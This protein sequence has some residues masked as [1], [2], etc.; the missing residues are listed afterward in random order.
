MP[1]G[2]DVDFG[3]LPP[4]QIRSLIREK[5]PDAV[6]G[7]A[8]GA[9]PANAATSAAPPAEERGSLMD[10]VMQGVTFGFA[11]EIA[12]GFGGVMDWMGFGPKGSEGTFSE[13]YDR[14]VNKAR[15]NLDAYR[16]RNPT[17]ALVGEIGGAV[18]TLPVAGAMNI[19]RAPAAISKAAPLAA[20]AANSVG[21]GAAA[22]ANSAATGAAY[23]AAYG[24]GAA[25]GDIGERASGALEGGTMGGILGAAAPA[26]IGVG[27]KALSAA[28]G[29]P[30][31]ALKNAAAPRRQ[32]E[33]MMVEAAKKDAATAG[34]TLDDTAL[35]LEIMNSQGVPIRPL[36]TGATTRDLG[37]TALSAS[38]QGKDILNEMVNKRF[39]TQAARAADT[40]TKFAPGVNAPA[41]RKFLEQAGKAARTPL[42]RQAYKEGASIWNPELQQLTLSPSMQKA[43]RKAEKIGADKAAIENVRPPTHPFKVNKDGTLEMV[44][45]VQPNLRFWDAVKQSLDKQYK[46]AVRAGDS[47]GARDIQG[48]RHKLLEQLDAAAPTYK[49]ARGVAQTFFGADDALE[50]GKA[51]T[52]RPGDNAGVRDALAQM[53]K[54]ERELFGEGFATQIIDDLRNVRYRQTITTK[55]MESPAARE[56]FELALGPKAAREMEAMLQI[57]SIMDLGRAAIQG[58]AVDRQRDVMNALT[59]MGIGTGVGLWATNNPGDMKT[60]IIAGLVAG[61][62]R[63]GRAVAG[64][65]SAA[66]NEAVARELAT[67]LASDN[68]QTFRRAIERIAASPKMFEALRTGHDRLTRAVLPVITPK[69]GTPVPALA[70]SGGSQP[71]AADGDGN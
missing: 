52:R 62:L 45:G 47:G 71:A 10:P 66:G 59:Q 51:F 40:I 49:K 65:L 14:T 60:W 19:V 3:D 50:A 41:K 61:G 1:D 36:D 35:G 54:P 4:D 18:A 43:I 20:R 13:G 23:G 48:I 68:P 11:D 57:E 42:Y 34:R 16:E 21:R 70:D 9:T 69:G 5:F 8:G 17:T 27:K 28:V 58:G 56:R 22:T 63:G 6:G 64:R 7:S 25:D 32:A 53:S 44:P 46:K 15:G 12:G 24:A 37:R 55:I 67:M 26:V 30:A 29:T 31:K 33:R 39:E 2:T 38:P